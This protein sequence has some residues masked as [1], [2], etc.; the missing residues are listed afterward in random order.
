ME[1]WKGDYNI[2]TLIRNANAFNVEKVFY[3][4]KRRFDPRGAVGTHHY[5]DVVHLSGSIYELVKYKKDYT[6]IAIDNNVP[7]TQ[8]L[9]NF[10]WSML[11]KRP[12]LLF[13]EEGVGLTE[14]AKKLADYTI[15]IEQYGSVRSMNVGTASGIVIHH[16]INSLR[17]S[18]DH[19]SGR[20]GRCGG[21]GNVQ[22]VSLQPSDPLY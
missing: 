11:E 14:E 16:C 5:V 22:N 10:D 13:G 20:L 21:I 19:D 4:G 8:K 12:L 2:G 18:I 1:H 7:N 3:V 6:F 17:S 9:R 15:E